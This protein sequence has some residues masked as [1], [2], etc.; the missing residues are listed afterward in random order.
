VTLRPLADRLPW[1]RGF[2]A[3]VVALVPDAPIVA[4]GSPGMRGLRE[5]MLAW[6][7]LSPKGRAELEGRARELLN[8]ERGG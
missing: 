4:D 8:R 2:K 5:M 6:G 7:S 1:I 3:S